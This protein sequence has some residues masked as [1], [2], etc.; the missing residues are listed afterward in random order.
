MT[1]NMSVRIER[2]MD[3]PLPEVSSVGLSELDADVLSVVVAKRLILS[4]LGVIL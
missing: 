2:F 4:H 3:C 1:N